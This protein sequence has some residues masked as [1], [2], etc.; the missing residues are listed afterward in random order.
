MLT[1]QHT[2]TISKLRTLKAKLHARAEK[3]SWPTIKSIIEQHQMNYEP[4]F[5]KMAK[6]GKKMHGKNIHGKKW[7]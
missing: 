5:S 4:T 1:T 7:V 6:N 2:E 3:I